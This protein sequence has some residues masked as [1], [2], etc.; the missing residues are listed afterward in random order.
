MLVSVTNFWNSALFGRVAVGVVRIDLARL[1]GGEQ[2][3]VEQ[4]H[5][6]VLARLQLARDLVRLVG[7]G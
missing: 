7:H 3:L 4:L 6:E 5:A 2:R 1:H